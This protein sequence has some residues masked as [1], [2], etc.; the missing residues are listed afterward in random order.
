MLV[1]IHVP[2]LYTDIIRLIKILMQLIN[3][4]KFKMKYMLKIIHT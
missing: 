4:I 2:D 3:C 1:V